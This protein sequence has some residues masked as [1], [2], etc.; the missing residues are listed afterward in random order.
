ML[1]TEEAGIQAFI[2]AHSFPHR[3][4]AATSRSS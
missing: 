1:Q 2:K 4:K 3:R